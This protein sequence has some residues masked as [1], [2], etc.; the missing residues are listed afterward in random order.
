MS[1]KRGMLYLGTGMAAILVV[2]LFVAL[3]GNRDNPKETVIHITPPSP[4][5]Q[6][7][8]QSETVSV[9]VSTTNQT[10]SIK[11]EISVTETVSAEEILYININTADKTELMKLSGIGEQLA[12]A[13]ISH[14]D[15]CG[16]FANIEEI[17]LVDGIGDAIFGRICNYIYVENPVYTEPTEQTEPTEPTE[18]TETI[19]APPLTLEDVAPIDL[20]TATVEEL[21][22]LPHV[23]EEIAV[24]IIELRTAIQYFSHEYE[25]LY[26]DELEQNQVAE[27]LEF[28]TVGQ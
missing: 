26:I 18:T 20:N 6:A 27:I 3:S 28:V 12:E 4:T 25:L 9:I 14:R 2:S 22:L 21:V 13:I 5:T 15:A 17:M 8:E 7:Q 24:K 11:T 16:D 1:D 23:T 10:E 19:T